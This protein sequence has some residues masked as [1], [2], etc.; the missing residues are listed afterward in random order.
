MGQGPGGS[1]C[2]LL[3]LA[4][5]PRQSLTFPNL[6]CPIYKR[7]MTLH[8]LVAV[9]FISFAKGF[10]TILTTWLVQERFKNGWKTVK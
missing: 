8:G 9:I 3:L 2:L 6:R 5:D 10:M 4:A 7:G 1:L